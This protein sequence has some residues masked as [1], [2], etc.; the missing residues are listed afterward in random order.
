MEPEDY[1]LLMKVF[2]V[3]SLLMIKYMDKEHSVLSLKG[4]FMENGNKEV[5]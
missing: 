2:L 5:W 1:S 3:E 4:S